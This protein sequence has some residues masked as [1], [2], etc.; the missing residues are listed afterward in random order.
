[1]KR[2]AAERTAKWWQ[3]KV[4]SSVNDMIKISES[5]PIPVLVLDNLQTSLI[6]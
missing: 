3:R 5:H 1:M 4:G 2:D 6:A